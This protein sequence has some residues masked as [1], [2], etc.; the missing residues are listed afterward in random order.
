MGSKTVLTR[1]EKPREKMRL[2][3]LLEKILIKEVMK[4]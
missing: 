1:E 3:I 2:K 4:F